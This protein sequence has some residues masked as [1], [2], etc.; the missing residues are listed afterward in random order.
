METLKDAGPKPEHCELLGPFALFVQGALGI[1]ALAVL[2][3]KRQRERPQR[4]LLVWFM[5]ASKQVIGAMLVHAANLLLSLLSSGSFTTD[6]TP[7][8]IMA[9]SIPARFRL[10]RR[11]REPTPGDDDDSYHSNP[12]SFYLL[13][14]GIDTTIGVLILIYILRVLQKIVETVPIPGLRT[15]TKSG[16]YGDPPNWIYWA[17]QCSIYFTGLMGMKFVVWIIFAVFPWLGRV[18][19]WLLAWTEGNRNLQVFFVMFFF[20]LVMNGFQ[21]YVIDSFIKHNFAPNEF[22]DAPIEHR[23]AR[24]STDST[25][26]TSSIDSEGGQRLIRS[27]PQKPQGS[28]RVDEYDPEFDG[29]NSPPTNRPVSLSQKSLNSSMRL[30]PGSRGPSTPGY[31]DGEEEWG[32]NGSGSS[33]RFGDDESTLVGRD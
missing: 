8:S 10:L 27:P 33:T 25:I 7:A 11:D 9:A 26:S 30:L 18:G 1:L 17:K 3:W 20:P 21:Y 19:D 32:R 24:R 22:G 15:G 13:N 31:A 14:L 4:P 6:P 16:Y 5:D 23:R 12:C 29:S 2:V 28:S